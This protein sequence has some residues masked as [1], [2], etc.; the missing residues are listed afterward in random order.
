MNLKSIKVRLVLL[1]T[2]VALVVGGSITLVSIPKF[3]EAMI[4]ARLDQLDSVRV[5]KTGEI[6]ELFEDLKDLLLMTAVRDETIEAMKGFTSSFHELSK[7]DIDINTVKNE[8]INHYNSNFINKIN[9]DIP[10]VPSKRATKDYLPKSKEGLIAQKLYILDNPSPI[11]EKNNLMFQNDSSNYSKIHKK[12]HKSFNETLTHF[13]LY[14][15]FLVDNDGYVVYTDFKEKDY[16]TNLLSGPY[17]NSGLA[18]AFKRAKNAPKEK[19]IFED[20]APYEPSYNMPAAFIASP[21]FEND[22]RVGV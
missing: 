16:A 3:S 22:K 13:K 9:F 1:V 21:I 17:S 12:Y 20:F 15:I 7:M 10:G 18:K 8:L 11:G 14:D 5:S 2:L 4:K 19:I 6:K